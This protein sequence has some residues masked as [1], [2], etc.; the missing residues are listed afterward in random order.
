MLPIRDINPGRTVPL[1]TWLII[2]IT[3]AVFFFYQRPSEEFLYEKAAIPCEVT[4]GQALSA[5]EISGGPCSAGD[6]SAIF[7]SKSVLWSVMASVFFH[8]GLGH[9]L[10]NL[11]VL[12]IFG[13]NIEDRMGRLP[14]GLF[15]LVAG[16]VA[17]ATH[18]LA[19]PASTIP[20]VGASG[21]IAGVMGA[22]A[23]VFP[24]AR[25]L[26]IVPPFFF[27]PFQMPAVVFLGIWFISQF[28]LAGTSTNI[29]WEAH[30]GG[31]IFGLLIA[32]LSRRRLLYR[33]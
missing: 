31:F 11:W 26:S 23:V 4:T 24:G 15:Y 2:G 20:V 7:G 13:N 32:L 16:L 33:R 30:V 10:G 9:L 12:A 8:G 29:A 21:A 25:V 1:T 27:A 6:G 18:I 28:F 22:Y 5:R 14:Y 17:A 3:A 19:H